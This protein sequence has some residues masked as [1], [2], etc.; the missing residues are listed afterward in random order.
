MKPLLTDGIE[1]LRVGPQNDPEFTVSQDEA[2]QFDPPPARERELTD[3]IAETALEL[4]APSFVEGHV[5]HVAQGGQAFKVRI[6]DSQFGKQVDDGRPFSKGDFLIVELRT[7]TF[8]TP[9]GLRVER[10][11]VR[12]LNHQRRDEQ[13]SLF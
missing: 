11:V 8:A 3:S 4:L 12:V 1:R 9:R 5:W 6:L 7:R 13:G 10:E 2:T